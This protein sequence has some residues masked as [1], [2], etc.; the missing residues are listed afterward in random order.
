MKKIEEAYQTHKLPEDLKE[1]ITDPYA[2][3][4]SIDSLVEEWEREE[5][6]TLRKRRKN[7]FFQKI[8]FGQKDILQ[9][10]DSYLEQFQDLLEDNMDFTVGVLE[11]L[12][13]ENFLELA[14]LV[15]F[16]VTHYI[17]NK[18]YIN[19]R[20]EGLNQAM[21]GIRYVDNR[22]SY[23]HEELKEFVTK[24]LEKMKKEKQLEKKQ[25]V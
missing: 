9:R 23:T 22:H 7:H 20:I 12:T 11:V 21:N 24:L 8:I 17:G 2:L 19:S 18:G 13:D 10:E 4:L 15:D 25:D 3:V 6:E 16:I 14:R 1:E 5:K